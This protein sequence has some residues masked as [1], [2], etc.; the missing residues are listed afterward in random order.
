M[1]ETSF[2]CLSRWPVKR[3]SYNGDCI[4]FARVAVPAFDPSAASA[5]KQHAALLGAAQEHLG[6][7]LAEL[8]VAMPSLAACGFKASFGKRPP[9]TASMQQVSSRMA[10]GAHEQD[11]TSVAVAA[12]TRSVG[13]DTQALRTLVTRA[14]EALA[15]I[16]Q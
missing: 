16:A 9:A 7:L 13:V 12:V 14:R 10:G 5:A 15:Q 2:S 1:Q 8:Y 3:C 6:S 4:E 11:A